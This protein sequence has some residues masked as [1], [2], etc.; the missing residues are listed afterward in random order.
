MLFNWTPNFIEAIYDGKFI[1]FPPFEEACRTDPS[2]GI[3]KELTHD[4]GNPSGG[5]LKIGVWKGFPDKW[6]GAYEV[7]Q[8]IN[9]T[10]LDVAVQAK[11]VDV[12]KMEEEDAAKKW[13]ADNEDRWKTWIAQ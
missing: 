6:P 1:E 7:L 9:F 3:N 2:W 8:K 12:D 4:C 11:L 10:N 5:Y 13:L